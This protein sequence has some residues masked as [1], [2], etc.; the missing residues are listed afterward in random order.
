MM[1]QGLSSYI[2]M[3]GYLS[4]YLPFRS[5]DSCRRLPEPKHHSG[6]VLKTRPLGFHIVLKTRPLGF[7]IVLKTRPLGFNIVLKHGR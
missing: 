4:I 7:H 6:Y 3:S 1:K 2:A 5:C